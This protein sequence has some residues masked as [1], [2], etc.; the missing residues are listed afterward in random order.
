MNDD[1]QRSRPSR[2]KMGA[3]E[4]RPSD[5]SDDDEKLAG[6]S[7]PKDRSM[8]LVQALSCGPLTGEGIQG[9]PSLKKWLVWRSGN[10]R[11][12]FGACV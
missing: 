7:P 4:S 6:M 8:S 10:T 9:F 5:D 1:K 3:E 2:S 11:A 12:V